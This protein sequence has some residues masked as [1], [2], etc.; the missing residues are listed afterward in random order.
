VFAVEGTTA[1]RADERGKT[2]WGIEIPL[3]DEAGQSL[4]NGLYHL[5]VE[6]DQGRRQLKLLVMR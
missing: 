5:V 2:Y 6:T 1:L 3:K 4:A